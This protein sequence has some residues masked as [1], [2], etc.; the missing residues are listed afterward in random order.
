MRQQDYLLS[1]FIDLLEM[2]KDSNL[3]KIMPTKLFS[4]KKQY[5]MVSS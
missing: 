5:L 1:K 3:L 4:N 2:A